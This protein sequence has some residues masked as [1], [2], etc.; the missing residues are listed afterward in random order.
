MSR[1]I[2]EFLVM[3]AAERGAAANTLAAY[4]RDLE[5]A[6]EAIG[7]LAGARKTGLARLG[8]GCVCGGGCADGA[9]SSCAAIGAAR[10]A[11]DAQIAILME[12]PLAIPG[13]LA[14]TVRFSQEASTPLRYSSVEDPVEL[15]RGSSR[16]G[17]T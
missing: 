5:G 10:K 3:L 9:V 6:E 2:D 15:V 13:K 14:R 17:R 7:D 8:Q 12:D 1:E 11:A 4:R 16:T